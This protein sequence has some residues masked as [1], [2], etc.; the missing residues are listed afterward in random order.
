MAKVKKVFACT[1]CGG[2]QARWAGKCPDCGAWDT[3]EEHKLDAAADRDPHKGLVEGWA[4]TIAGG[5]DTAGVAGGVAG[6]PKAA[7]IDEVAPDPSSAERISTGINE[8]DRVLGLGEHG[9]GLVPGSAVLIGGEPGIGKSTL[10]MQAAAGWAS[11]GD[12]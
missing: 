12:P 8:F 2:T 7:P 11:V 6:S 4:N 9:A 5:E 10:L 1:A 3:L